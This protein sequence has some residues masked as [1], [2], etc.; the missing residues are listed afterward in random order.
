MDDPLSVEE[1]EMPKLEPGQSEVQPEEEVPIERE[2]GE[3]H[4]VELLP[5]SLY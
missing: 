1:T 5:T 4:T 3:V 2:P